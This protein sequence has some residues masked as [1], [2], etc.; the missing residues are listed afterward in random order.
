[1]KQQ[2][3]IAGLACTVLGVMFVLTGAPPTL[4]AFIIGIGV[5][6]K[7]AYLFFLP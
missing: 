3:L 2:M 4:V 5:G 6:L 7:I 1:M